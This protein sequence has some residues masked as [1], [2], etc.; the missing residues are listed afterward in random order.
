MGTY[1]LT[2]AA[3]GIGA[4]L[5]QTLRG[6]GHRVISVD[7]RGAD[8]VADLATARGRQAAVAAVRELAPEGL[9]GLVPLAGVGASG[10]AGALITSVNYFGTVEFVEGARDLV[11]KK[12]GAIV[13]LCSNSATM[14]AAEGRLLDSLLSGNEAEARRISEEEDNGMQYMVGKRALAYWMRRN[15]TAYARAG[16]RINAVAPGPVDTAMTRPLFDKPE[17]ATILQQLLAATPLGRAGQPEEVARVISFLLSP[18]ASYICGS[19]V[20]VD[21]G[22]DAATRSDHL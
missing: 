22:Y 1:A 17:M 21:G 2:G 11:A 7:L 13:L 15:T 18:D 14:S 9:D 5:A 19:L 4:S 10:P 3:S 6:Q 16:I 20:F 12:Q 8:I